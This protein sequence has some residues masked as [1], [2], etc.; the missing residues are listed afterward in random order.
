MA[1]D[2]TN[3]LSLLAVKSP[4]N[5]AT[6]LLDRIRTLILSGKLPAG[7]VFPAESD[8][9]EELG[10]GRTTLREA[11]KALENGGFITRTKRGTRVNEEDEIAKS[12]PLNTALESSDY[13]DLIEFRATI[14]SQ[15][16]CLAAQRATSEHITNLHNYYD[17]MKH[18]QDDIQK[19]SCYDTKFHMELASASHNQLFRRVMLMSWDV[20]ASGVYFAFTIDTKENV[21]Q[22]LSSHAA[23]LR[24]VEARDCQQARD[25]MFG[26]L[27]IIR[28]R[29]SPF[30]T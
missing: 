24:A 11:Y 12:L 10:V 18:Y 20:F 5:I 1:L 27:S 28:M 2:M 30:T 4:G 16:A 26:H 6:Q 22:A 15:I 19:L 7:F 14:E 25:A 21:K 9:C 29:Q 13:E 8:L 3:M 23:I 17:K